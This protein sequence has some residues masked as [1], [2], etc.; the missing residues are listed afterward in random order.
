MRVET[1]APGADTGPV[2]QHDAGEAGGVVV[3]GRLRATA[4]VS[5]RVLEAG[6]AFLFQSNQPHRFRSDG[7][8][9]C[10]IVRALSPPP[11]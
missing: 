10:V 11:R 7:D 1:Y 6:D 8:V 9:D 3:S 5:E 2:D 4:G